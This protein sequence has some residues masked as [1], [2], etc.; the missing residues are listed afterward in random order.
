M[1]T[2]HHDRNGLLTPKLVT[3][4]RDGYTLSMLRADIMAGMTVAIVAL[5]LSMALAIASGTTPDR[6]LATAIVAGFLISAFSGS[7]FQI[8]GPTGAFV[9]IVFQVIHDHGYD[10]LVLSTLMAGFILIAFALARFGTYIKYIPYPVVTGF[11]SGIALIILTSQVPEL[12]GLGLK[13]PPPDFI[14]KWAAILEQIRHTKPGALTIGGMTLV[15]ILV[16]RHVAPRAP[17][18][19]IGI[20]IGALVTALGGMNVETIGSRFGDIPRTLPV[21]AWPDISVQR[22]VTLAPSA[23][24]I[25]LLAGIESLLSAVVAD[26][27]TGRK[28]RSNCELLG[29]GIANIGSALFGGMPATGAIARTATNVRAGGLSP[30]S[31]MVHAA[32]LLVLMMVAAPLARYLPMPSLAAVLVM[33]AWGMSE[34]DRFRRLLKAPPGDILVLLL[35]FV[36]TVLVDLTLAIQVGVVLAAL[37]FVHRITQ[38]MEEEQGLHLV[39]EDTDDFARVRSVYSPESGGSR[40]TVIYRING[41]FFF[42]IAGK[43]ADILENIGQVPDTLILDM[44]AVPVI[45]ATAAHALDGFIDHCL[46]KGIVVRLAGVRSYPLRILKDLGVDRKVEA[47]LSRSERGDDGP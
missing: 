31:G 2:S 30:V 39:D 7:R 46:R 17:V 22:L 4:L 14:G 37:L 8:G 29:Q 26:G 36:L 13:N 12:L 11:T 6:G 10:G 9:V 47:I 32:V 19:L 23:F 18:F 33:V 28:H 27:M 16:V 3:V 5:P 40:R 25:A 34:I 43:L 35:T 24:T 21:P 45:D 15:V 41:P 38:V 42:G 20:S 44:E 1:G